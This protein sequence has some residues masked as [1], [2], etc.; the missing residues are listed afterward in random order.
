M[1]CWCNKL[2]SLCPDVLVGVSRCFGERTCTLNIKKYFPDSHN[3]VAHTTTEVMLA[4]DDHLIETHAVQIS[5]CHGFASIC[6]TKGHI[7]EKFCKAEAPK[8]KF[9]EYP[10]SSLIRK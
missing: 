2:Q 9:C 3:E 8:S 5:T 1:S 6:F 10:L 4:Q 7:D